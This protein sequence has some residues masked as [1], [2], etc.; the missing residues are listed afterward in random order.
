MFSSILY[1]K[2][3][4]LLM[5]LNCGYSIG[6]EWL[7]L[8]LIILAA[9]IVDRNDTSSF[10]RSRSSSMSSLENVSKEGVQSL[11]FSDSYTR[12]TG[13][14]RQMFNLWFKPQTK[15]RHV[16]VKHGC[17]WQKHSQ[18]MAKVSKSYILTPPTPWGMGC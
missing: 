10:S 14:C 17:P 12:K 3:H 8:I 1:V 13:N 9:T 6:S 7:K 4:T 15:A 16:F 2:H 11:V 18:N 5:H